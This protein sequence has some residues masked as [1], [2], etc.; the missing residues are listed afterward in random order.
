MKSIVSFI[1]LGIVASLLFISDAEAI[2]LGVEPGEINLSNVPLDKKYQASIS[3]LFTFLVK[4][5][6]KIRS[7]PNLGNQI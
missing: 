4:T 7:S 1:L 6:R 2:G 3:C 5:L